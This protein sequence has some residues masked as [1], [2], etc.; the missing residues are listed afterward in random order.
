MTKKK[1]LRKQV[2]ETVQQRINPLFELDNGSLEVVRV[3]KKS[4]R[5]QVRLAGSY[6][7]S[8]CRNVLVKFVIEPI[9]SSE[10]EE[11]QSVELV[12]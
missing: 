5:V 1:T 9:L 11:I 4:G 6:G 7:G 2:E 12:D 3:Q 8:P 10:F